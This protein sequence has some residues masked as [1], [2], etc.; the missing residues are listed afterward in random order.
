V[1]E[2]PSISLSFSNTLIWLL[3]ESSTTVAVSSFAE[4]GS[5]AAVIDSDTDASLCFRITDGVAETISTVVV[6]RGL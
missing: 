2:S 5:F 6:G 4:G 1:S 3:F